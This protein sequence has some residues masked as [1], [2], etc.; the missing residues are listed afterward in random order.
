MIRIIRRNIYRILS[1]VFAHATLVEGCLKGTETR[2]RCL[3][4]DNSTFS[5]FLMARMYAEP[6][7]IMRKW[8]LCIPALRHHIQANQDAFDLCFAV[9]PKFYESV[10]KG[11]Y[12]YKCTEYVRQ[13]IDTSGLWED[14]RSRFSKTKRQISSRFTEKYGLGYRISNDTQEFNHFY[15]RMFIPHIQKRFKDLSQVDSYEEMKQYFLHGQLLLVTKGS[16]VVAGALFQIQDE[17]LIFR[18]TGVLDGDE[19]HIDG[20]AQLALYY[21]QLKYANDNKLRAVD[22]MMSSSFMNDGVYTNKR[23]WGASVVPDH[24]STTWIYIFNAVPS[25]KLAQCFERNPAIIYSPEGL[26]GFVGVSGATLL[27]AESIDEL[28]RRYRVGGLHGFTVVTSAGA[29]ESIKA[30]SG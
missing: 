11:L 24:Q 13:V 8:R 14:V 30:A 18:R 9:L 26:K 12:Y 27:S 4:V 29:F 17:T 5:E 16:E 15:H 3:F 23:E 1:K 22:T 19:A 28:T 6:P 10:F 2:F 7:V 20:G 21:F 25:E